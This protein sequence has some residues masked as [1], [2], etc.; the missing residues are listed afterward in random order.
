[1]LQY[2]KLQSVHENTACVFPHRSQL[3]PSVDEVDTEL[4]LRKSDF[5]ITKDCSPQVAQCCSVEDEDVLRFFWDDLVLDSPS[6]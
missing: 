4:D 3:G 5:D 1:M 6:F 2:I